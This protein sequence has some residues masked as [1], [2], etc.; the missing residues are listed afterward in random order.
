MQA[1]SQ[2]TQDSHFGAVREERNG[3]STLMDGMRCPD[4]GADQGGTVDVFS[5][6]TFVR[7]V[8]LSVFVPPKAYNEHIVREE[9]RVKALSHDR[10]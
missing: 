2:W 9:Y 6:L 4:F 10:N 5:P 3:S 8:F 1:L 7:G